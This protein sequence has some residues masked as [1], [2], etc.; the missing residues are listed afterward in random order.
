MAARRA[1]ARIPAGARYRPKW[2]LA[3]DMLDELAGWGLTPLVVAADAGYGTNAE[4]RAGL[5]ERG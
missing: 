4:F 5:A 2:Q 1:R 3:L